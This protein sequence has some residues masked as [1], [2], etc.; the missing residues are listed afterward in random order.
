MSIGIVRRWPLAVTAS[1]TLALSACGGS[2]HE[3]LK[4]WMAEATKDARGKIPPLPAVR[5]YE[6]TDYSVSSLLDPFKSAKLELGKLPGGGSTL[7]PNYEAREMR[8]SLLEKYPLES[9]KMIGFVRIGK[10][11]MAVVQV[12]QHVK[13]VKVG[14]Y[15]GQDFGIVTGISETEI[16]LKELVQDS[17]GD[18]S[19]RTSSLLLQEAKEG[20]K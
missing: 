1:I 6:P 12:D 18:W 10:S 2:D 4:Q 19:E 20:K 14:D 5:P 7:K 9:I 17:A 3:D 15:M 8:N 16:S 13:Q 11:D